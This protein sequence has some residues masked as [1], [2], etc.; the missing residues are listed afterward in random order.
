MGSLEYKVAEKR[1]LHGMESDTG[2]QGNLLGRI[3]GMSLAEFES[4]VG[5]L[6]DKQ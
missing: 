1:R 4:H 6:R 5:R 2:S 3:S